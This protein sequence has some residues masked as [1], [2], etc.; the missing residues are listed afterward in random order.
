MVT[1]AL[2]ARGNLMSLRVEPPQVTRPAEG[3]A[4]AKPDWKPLFAAAGLDPSRFT[5]SVPRWLPSEPFDAREDWDGSYAGTP[6]VPI[7][8]GAASWLGK[9]VWFEIISPW[10]RP[11]RMQAATDAAGRIARDVAIM[12]IIL[13]VMMTGVLLAR[14]NLRLGRGD[15]RGA[16][17][18]A[19]FTSVFFLLEWLFLAHH[20][21]AVGDEFE[22]FLLAVAQGVFSGVFIWL[23]YVAIE[24]IARRRW[25]DLLISWSR[26]LAGRFRDPLVGRD[27][28]VGIL[29]GSGVTL[30]LSLSNGLPTGSIWRA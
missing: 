28:L 21:A 2:D 1:I 6:D 23:I 17:R 16:L 18:V 8:V 27:V 24:P 4:G 15:R 3:A 29:F 13:S 30:T 14:R 22:A 26:L 5:P 19:L 12:F 11:A 10:S 9:P 20:V 25:P 7:H